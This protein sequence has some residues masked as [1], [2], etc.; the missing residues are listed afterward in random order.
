MPQ[1]L[2][3]VAWLDGGVVSIDVSLSF[4]SIILSRREKTAQG[5]KI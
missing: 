1:W 5:A 3:P 2:Q 4:L